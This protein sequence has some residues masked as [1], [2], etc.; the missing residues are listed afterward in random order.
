MTTKGRNIFD[1]FKNLGESLKIA[2]PEFEWNLERF[3]LRGKK[4]IQGWYGGGGRKVG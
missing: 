2:F 3:S 4:S 1:K